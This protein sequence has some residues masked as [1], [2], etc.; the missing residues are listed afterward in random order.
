MGEVEGMDVVY[1]TKGKWGNLKS[2]TNGSRE[3]KQIGKGGCCF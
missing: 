3:R 2:P 1:G